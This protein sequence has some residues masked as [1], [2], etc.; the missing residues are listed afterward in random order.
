MKLHYF[1]EKRQTFYLGKSVLSR[2]RVP[3]ANWTG[4]EF[5][6]MRASHAKP[7]ENFIRLRKIICLLCETLICSTSKWSQSLQ[8]FFTCDGFNTCDV[9]AGVATR[10]KTIDQASAAMKTQSLIQPTPASC[11]TFYHQLSI[12][13]FIFEQFSLKRTT[14]KYLS[15]VFRYK[16][17][18]NP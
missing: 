8:I 13:V 18:P 9:I 2:N 12:P 7:N 15:F 14:C 16:Q 11:Q 6:R 3:D 1:R 5:L 17:A 10:R 4:S